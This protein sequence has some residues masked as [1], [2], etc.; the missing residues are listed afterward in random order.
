MKFFASLMLLGLFVGC[1]ALET[2][3]RS[4]AA[5]KAHQNFLKKREQNQDHEWRPGRE[6]ANN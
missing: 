6:N 4:P 2:Y 5:K 1:A 3:D